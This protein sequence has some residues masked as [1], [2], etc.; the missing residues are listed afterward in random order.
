M[1]ACV[2]VCV[3]VCARARVRVSVCDKSMNH[4]AFAYKNTRSFNYNEIFLQEM[5]VPIGKEARQTQHMFLHKNKNTR[6]H[7]NTHRHTPT[8]TRKHTH[9]HTRTYTHFA[10]PIH[11]LTCCGHKAPMRAGQ[12]VKSWA[13]LD[14]GSV[15]RSKWP[16]F[17]DMP[18]CVQIGVKCAHFCWWQMLLFV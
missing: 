1:C 4:T 6:V 10:H 14:S 2:R 8:H 11:M 7:T 12:G 17:L 18:T 16:S 15:H 13:R 5:V 3:C 9:T